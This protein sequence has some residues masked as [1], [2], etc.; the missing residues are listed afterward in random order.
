MEEN[1][2]MMKFTP[3][4]SPAP[5][6]EAVDESANQ[7]CD[8]RRGCGPVPDP[9]GA[10]TATAAVA[11]AEPTAKPHPQPPGQIDLRQLVARAN[12]G[13]PQSL[14]RLREVLDA[15]PAIW[16][17]V[18][19]LAA[20]ARLTLA[21]LIA[22]GDQLLFESIQRKAA[23]LETELLVACP[24][25]LEQL[26]VQRV[27]AC[28][29]QLQYADAMV[30]SA[31][32]NLAQGKFWSQQ[33]DRAHRRYHSAVKQLLAIREILPKAGETTAE[34]ATAG[35]AS[36]EPTGV[37]HAD[38]GFQPRPAGSNG[39]GKATGSRCCNGTVPKPGDGPNPVNGT[40]INRILMFSQAKEV[41][42]AAD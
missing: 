10:D 40:P 2:A 19:D 9:H 25:P 39:N 36:P 23:D 26:G 24:T 1:T 33:Q 6:S 21:R 8:A 28:W 35:S 42:S 32:D 18:G 4:L 34:S 13:D 12:E 7:P 31:R 11:D 38:S 30:C 5:A 17:R 3:N 29:L 41:A 27:V 16:Q 37:R 20:H 22:D 15:N 14:Q